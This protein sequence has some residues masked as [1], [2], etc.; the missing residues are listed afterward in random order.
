MSETWIGTLFLSSF[1]FPCTQYS[2]LNFFFQTLW[3]FSPEQLFFLDYL[4]VV[5]F[6]IFPCFRVL[7]HEHLRRYDP[8]FLPFLTIQ[9]FITS[10][11]RISWITQLSYVTMQGQ[12]INFF[13]FVL[14][15]CFRSR[16]CLLYFHIIWEIWPYLQ[17]RIKLHKWN[18]Q[19]SRK[20]YLY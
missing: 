15:V 7:F 11:Q 13:F 12:S 6:L 17:A 10:F 4:N 3:S 19:I 16:H 8:I 5:T 18:T 2:S 20:I 14:S 1:F 9:L